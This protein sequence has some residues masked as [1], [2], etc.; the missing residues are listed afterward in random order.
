MI[1]YGAEN[2]LK[3][4]FVAESMDFNQVRIESGNHL[5]DRMLDRLPD[6]CAVKADLRTLQDVSAY[7]TTRRYS[8]PR[9]AVPR[10]PKP[11][12]ILRW[13]AALDRAVLRC[14]AHFSI[15]QDGPDYRATT[16]AALR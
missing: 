12:D 15:R 14:D 7:S 6:A 16:T 3:A 11:E 2:L 1:C 4:L 5:L 9:G 10:Q 13:I 8:T